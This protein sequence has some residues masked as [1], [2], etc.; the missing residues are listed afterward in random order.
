MRRTFL[1]FQSSFRTTALRYRCEVPPLHAIPRHQLVFT[2]EKRDMPEG[3]V[4]N[5][6]TIRSQL[7]CLSRRRGPAPDA[8]DHVRVRIGHGIVFIY[9]A[10]K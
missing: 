4:T 8:R 2:Y 5:N 6:G 3:R 10:V 7:T 9:R 1:S